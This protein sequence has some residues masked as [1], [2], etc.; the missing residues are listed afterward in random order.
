MSNSNRRFYTS[1][2]DTISASTLKPLTYFEWVKYESTFN[3]ENAFEQYTIYLNQWYLQKG[4]STAAS[5]TVFVRE[6]YVN[7]LKQIALEYTTPDEKRFLENIN[8]QDN[9]DL[10]IALPFFAKKLKQ[11]AIYYASQRDEIKFSPIKANLKGSSYGISQIIYKQVADILKYDPY[12]DTQLN[13]IGITI[14]EILTNLKVDIVELYDTEQNYF[15]IPPTA[16]KEEYVN[17]TTDRYNYFNLSIVPDSTRLFLSTTFTESLIELI[18]QVPVIL[19]SGIPTDDAPDGDITI[20]SGESVALAITDIVTGTELD[21]LD[22]SQFTDYS[23]TGKL[24]ISYEKLA[25]QKYSGTDYYYLSTGDTLADTVSGKLFTADS[26]HKDILN[27]FHPTIASRPG[28]N[29]F[30]QEYIGGFFQTT[31]I[32]LLNYTTLDFVY[33]F[34][35]ELNSIQYFP[36]PAS[37]GSGF[38]GSYEPVDTPVHYFENV[39]WNKHNITTHYNFGN[40]V[41]YRNITRM[42]PYQSIDD[43]HNNSTIGVSRHDDSFDYWSTDGS[44][45]WTNDDIFPQLDENIQPINIRT[46]QLLLGN[47]VLYKWKTDIYGNNFALVK[48]KIHPDFPTPVNNNT[49]RYDTEYI[50]TSVLSHSDNKNNVTGKYHDSKNITEQKSLTG[51]LYLRNNS[52][53]GIQTLTSSS[54]SGI[55]SKYASAGSINYRSGV[56]E[57]TDIKSELTSQLLDIDIIYDIIIFDTTNYTVFE[58]I[59]YDYTTGVISSGQENFTFIKKNYHDNTFEE[60]SNW[61]FD[62]AGNRIL[63][64]KSTIHHELSGTSDKMIYPEIYSYNTNSNNL[65]RLYPDPD[66]NT[67]QLI[68]ETSQF[69]LSSTD[70]DIDII[71][72][73]PPVL[74]FN[75]DSERF[76]IAQLGYDHPENMYLLKTDF[77]LY[78]ESIELIN[79]S[80]YRNKYL[81]YSVNPGNHELKEDYLYELNPSLSANSTWYHDTSANTLYLSCSADNETPVPVPDSSNIWTYGNT[82]TSF[83][84]ARDIVLCFDI[85]TCGTLDTPENTPNGVSVIFY[86]ANTIDGLKKYKGGSPGD[87]DEIANTGGLGPSFGYLSDESGNP[88]LSG[89]ETGHAAA[90]IDLPGLLGADDTLPPNNLTVLGP[91]DST[92]TFKDTTNL[93]FEGISIQNDITGKDDYSN[94]NF[95][96]CR[97]TLTDLGRQ[98]LV[99]MKSTPTSKFALVSDTKIS[100][101]FTLGYKIPSKLKVSLASSNS[102]VNNGIIAIKNITVTGST[103]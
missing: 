70:T 55:Y 4:V 81:T 5:Q 36:D 31:G 51:E 37:G 88:S 93:S 102:T 16:N 57:L 9:Q 21:R 41:Q 64:S 72:I 27:K 98:V 23:K 15:N 18:S 11:I 30:K 10:D 28:E 7:L 68:Y 99:H 12:V 100:D 24:N 58:K 77:R 35:P 74:T 65:R 53:T 94:L 91:Y 66:L 50:N 34:K 25:F 33:R 76:T 59:N 42:V 89:L 82:S 14:T 39:N 103:R 1:S 38:Y 61:W 46:D 86:R 73:A 8:Y 80:I 101:Y 62:E 83:S 92:G 6:L 97:V 75:K 60:Q 84:G 49:T 78:D 87:N 85:A 13:N 45:T 69:S 48:D 44:N 56:V 29:L 95:T 32:G 22:V 47:K 71:N 67:N 79:T 17:T 63:I 90:I 3:R 26:P 2:E 40:Q 54:L 20:Q 96:R 52:A 43:T 19:K